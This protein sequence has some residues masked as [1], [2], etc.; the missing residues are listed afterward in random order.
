VPSALCAKSYQFDVESMESLEA[1]YLPVAQLNDLLRLR[2]ELGMQVM[3]MMCE[4]LSVLGRTKEH[5]SR[6]QNKECGLHGYCTQAS[7]LE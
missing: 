4:E 5:L 7:A 2:P 1:A 3:S 6:C